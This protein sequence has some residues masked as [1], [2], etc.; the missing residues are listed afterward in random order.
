MRKILAA[1]VIG[2]VM[3]AANLVIHESGHAIT[4]LKFGGGV[5]SAEFFGLQIYPKIVNHGFSGYMGKVAYTGIGLGP[6]YGWVTL[7]GSG[8]TW[9]A[10]IVFLLLVYVLYFLKI[11]NFILETAALFGSLMFLDMLTYILGLRFTGLQE[12]LV[13][14]RYLGINQALFI[15]AAFILGLIQL[16][17]LWEGLKISGYWRY[18]V[19]SRIAE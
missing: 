19:Q 10:S 2:L 13:A 11:R 3:V 18:F 9:V 1:A 6:V 7:M 8:A 17:L 5:R 15:G 4:A 14:V 16:V 12:P